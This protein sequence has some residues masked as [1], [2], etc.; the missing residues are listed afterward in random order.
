[1]SLMGEEEKERDEKVEGDETGDLYLE[2]RTRE[3]Q[4]PQSTGANT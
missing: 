3:P 2:M 4:K 1:M